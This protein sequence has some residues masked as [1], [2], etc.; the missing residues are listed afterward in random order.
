ML[1]QLGKLLKYSLLLAEL[2][3]TTSYPWHKILILDA[4]KS[5][6]FENRHFGTVDIMGIDILRI[7]ILGLDI[8]GTDILALSPT[9]H[10]Q[11]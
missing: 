5:R 10:P 9:E 8:L 7:D 1:S 2:S 6:H 4:E 11:E 3:V